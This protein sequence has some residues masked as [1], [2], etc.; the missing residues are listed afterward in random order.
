MEEAAT[1]PEFS[2]QPWPETLEIKPL[3]ESSPSTD[4]GFKE[5]DSISFSVLSF[6]VLAESYLTPRSHNNL[7]ASAT[8]VVFNKELRRN[9][10][11]HTLEKLAKSFDIICLQE[12]D[13]AL[14]GIIVD[15]L[16]KLGY[17]YV[18]APRVGVPLASAD[19]KRGTDNIPSKPTQNDKRSDG[20]ATFFSTKV[21]KCA[22]YSVVHFDDLADE[23]RPPLHDDSSVTED[24]KQPTSSK[25]KWSHKKKKEN[26]LSGII[27]SYKR[28]NAALLLELEQIQSPS[29]ARRVVVA[30]AHL[31]WHPGYEYVKLSQAHYLLQKVKQFVMETMA[32]QKKSKGGDEA[33]D[34][35]VAIICGD[36]NSKPNSVVH[37]YFTKGDVDARTVA[38]WHFHYDEVGDQEELTAQMSA[39]TVAS[40]CEINKVE[41]DQDPGKY[42][43]DVDQDEEENDIGTAMSKD[44]AKVEHGDQLQT[45]LPAYE[46]HAGEISGVQP[47]KY[48]LDVTLNKFT[49]WLRILGQDAALETADE[50]RLRTGEGEM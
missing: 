20:C 46:S 50:E 44:S 33:H 39:M 45:E 28:R 10:L 41:L 23:D 36:M 3:D 47:V 18:Y 4:D 26:A 11:K 38:P 40:D 27:A 5:S 2:R 7:P 21:W 19:V 35:P 25:S 42:S 9:L 14:T 15:S 49:R 12:V 31:Y 16:T 48:L 37:S 22:N 6:N 32:L 13:N 1:L 24:V 17:S 30:N 8:E 34:K 43:Q 29:K